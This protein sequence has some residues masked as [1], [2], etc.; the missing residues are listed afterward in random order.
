MDL[1]LVR[2]LTSQ[3]ASIAWKRVVEKVLDVTTQSVSSK[4]AVEVVSRRD[5][6]IGELDD[7]IITSA[8]ELWKH[9]GSAIERNSKN[10]VGWWRHTEGKKAILILDGLSLRELPWLIKGALTNGL[11]IKSVS[12]FGA[13]CPSE[14]TLFAKAMGFQNRS[15]LANNGGRNNKLFKQMSTESTGHSWSLSKEYVK[16]GSSYIFWHH[17]PDTVLHEQVSAG[18]GLSTF[19]KKIDE[20]LNSVDFWNFVK[21]LKRDRSLIITSDHG[22]AVTTFFSDLNNKDEKTVRKLLKRKR[23]TQSKNMPEG[24]IPSVITRIEN[25]GK[26]YLVATGRRKWRSPGGYPVLV[27]GGLSLFEMLCPF[28]EFT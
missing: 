21:E 13:E 11:M 10:L 5:R 28:V 8:W 6:E 20:E 3:P 2:T 25:N 1:E 7:F 22:Y 12:A 18:Q 15:T 4:N 23:Y 19:T 24:T 16:R 27:H 26:E 17:W 14:T 9:F